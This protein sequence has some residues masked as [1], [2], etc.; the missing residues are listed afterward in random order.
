M[1]SE[2]LLSE[3]WRS[4]KGLLQHECADLMIADC[5]KGMLR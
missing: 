4:M 3:L 5:A 2:S 1:F